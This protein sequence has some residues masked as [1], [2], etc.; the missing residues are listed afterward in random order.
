MSAD[1]PRTLAQ[2][3]SCS[4]Q[5]QMLHIGMYVSCANL[6]QKKKKRKDCSNERL[7]TE[8]NKVVVMISGANSPLLRGKTGWRN[9]GALGAC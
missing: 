7:K 2:Q 3:V 5:G 4:R 1:Q 9:V 6:K 8:R